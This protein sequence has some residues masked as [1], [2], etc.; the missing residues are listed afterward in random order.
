MKRSVVFCNILTVAAALVV[1]WVVSI[2]VFQNMFVESEKRQ[3]RLLADA[4][5]AIPSGSYANFTK[6]VAR[7][8]EEAQLIKSG[9]VVAGAP[10]ARVYEFSDVKQALAAGSSEKV[11]GS[12]KMNGYSVT[13]DRKLRDGSILRLTSDTPS[14]AITLLGFLPAMLI[15]AIAAFLQAGSLVVQVT[16]PFDSAAASLRSAVESDTAGFGAYEE[17]YYE[18]LKSRAREMYDL[19]RKAGRLLSSL[20]YKYKRIQYLLNS[21][22]EGLVVLDKRQRVVIINNSALGF[23]GAEADVKGKNILQLTH[24]PGIIDAVKQVS[25]QGENAVLDMNGQDE[26]R[27]LR[28]LISPVLDEEKTNGGTVLLISDVTSIKRSEQIRSEFFANASHELKTPLTSIS[29]FAE[30]MESGFVNDPEKSKYYLHIIKD[31][32]KRMIDLISDIL[33]LSELEIAS[34]D[35]GTSRVSLKL[36]AQ[37]VRDSLAYQMK[38]RSVEVTVSGDDGTLKANPDRMT[39]LLLNLMDN[40]VKY[41]NL[42][43]RVDVAIKDMEK[44]VSVTVS[45]NGVGIPKN[46]RER[47]FERFYRVDKSRSRKLGG[48]GLGLSIVKHIVGLYKGTVKLESEEG[49]GTSIEVRLP[50][51]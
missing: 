6:Q 14:T 15:A 44:E 32:V 49:A 3:L 11:A 38:E 26:S 23:F 10:V 45:D 36:I 48:T 24:F 47:V 21:M 5:C 37:R 29:G 34:A 31:E 30:L 16:K 12:G 43:G 35:A 7:G 1:A 19:S 41:N 42:G 46:A 39:Q 28:I 25:A 17:P 27:I 8:I 18:E 40:A 9:K 51:E 50:R 13:V 22:G 20:K 2:S 4:A 33:K